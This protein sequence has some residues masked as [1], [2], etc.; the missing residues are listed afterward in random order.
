MLFTIIILYDFYA[1]FRLPMCKEFVDGLRICFD[2][3]LPVTLLYEGE[4]DQH[5][6]IMN[7][8]KSKSPA[9]QKM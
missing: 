8:Y 9:K 6:K 3:V 1:Y 2:F 5:N 4:K 7:T